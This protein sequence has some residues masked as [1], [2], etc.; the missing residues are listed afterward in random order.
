MVFHVRIDTNR[1]RREGR[2]S[3]FWDWVQFTLTLESLEH[4]T[5]DEASSRI[6]SRAAV[7][8]RFHVSIH[9]YNN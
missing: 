9:P 5:F 2:K 3:G 7:N 6:S 1:V 4:G 8:F